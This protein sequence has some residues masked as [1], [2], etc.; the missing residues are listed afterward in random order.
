MAVDTDKLMEFVGSVIGDLGA[1]L[2]AGG[3]VIGH[4]LGLYTALAQGPATP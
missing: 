2:A 3:V 4:R 1:T